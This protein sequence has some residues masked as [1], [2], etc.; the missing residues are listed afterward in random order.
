[1]LHLDGSE[2]NPTQAKTCGQ[3]HCCGSCLSGNQNTHVECPPCLLCAF[4]L[5]RQILQPR[6]LQCT[7]SQR[8]PLCLTP[9]CPPT[10]ITCP[11]TS[12]AHSKL[13][14]SAAC[15]HV[16][17]PNGM[18]SILHL[19]VRHSQAGNR[20]LTVRI[21]ALQASGP[22]STPGGCTFAGATRKRTSVAGLEPATA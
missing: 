21:L 16:P 7:A 11:F 18:T 17:A 6:L 19:T 3:S 1:M 5:C 12:F 8:C 15:C 22:G 9:R 10:C 14:G 13:T 2:H 20:G 4:V